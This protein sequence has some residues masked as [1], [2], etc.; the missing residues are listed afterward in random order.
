M[1][2]GEKVHFHA[3]WLPYRG[4]YKYVE[5]AKKQENRI[6]KLKKELADAK[7]AIKNK[8]KEIMDIKNARSYRVGSKVM[9]VPSKVKEKL[10]SLG[11]EK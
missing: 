1:K 8:D 2:A 9:Y 3:E 10:K 4:D 6:K 7:A 11:K 5:E